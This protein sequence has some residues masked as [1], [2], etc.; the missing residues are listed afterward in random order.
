MPEISEVRLTSEWVTQKNKARTIVGVEYLP[1]NKLKLVEGIDVVGKRLSATS[2]GKEMMLKFDDEPI[3]ITLGM[4]G[5]FKNFKE[6][7]D[8][9]VM[10]WKHGHIRFTM[11]DGD[12]FTWTDVRR[13]G[14]SLG[15]NWGKKRGPDI[16]DDE[17]GF[18]NN[19]LNNIQ[20][21]DF[22]KQTYEV[23]MNQQWFNGIGNYLRAEILG[24]WGV[25]PFQPIRNII[26]TPFLDHLIGQVRDSYRLGGGELYTWMNENKTPI[27]RDTTWGEWMQFYGKTESVTD[28]QK[29]TFWFDKKWKNK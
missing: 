10:A 2:R 21:R 17:I 22:D 11:S 18:R 15:T 27:I 24:K 8:D 3:V 5:G 20:H 13:F 4:S 7:M 6:R 23:L 26:D 28:K 16:F 9:S 14:K 1:S 19:I 25:N 12:T 29:R